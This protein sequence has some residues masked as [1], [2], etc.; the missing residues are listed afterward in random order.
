MKKPNVIVTKVVSGTVATSILISSCNIVEYNLDNSVYGSFAPNGTK[1]VALIDISDTNLSADVV[2]KIKAISQIVNEIINNPNAA[3][4]FAEN[5][6]IYLHGKELDFKINLSHEEKRLLMAFA[7]KDMMNAIKE[8][9]FESFLRIGKERGYIGV[10]GNR[11]KEDLRSLFKSEEEYNKFMESIEGSGTVL[12]GAPGAPGGSGMP[13]GGNTGG[14]NTGGDNSGDE[15]PGQPGPVVAG[16]A[17]VVA[18]AGAI[19]YVGVESIGIAQVG[20]YLHVGVVGPPGEVGVPGQRS[21]PLNN[22]EPVIKLW[23]D[24]NQPVEISDF[25]NEMIDEQIDVLTESVM[26]HYPEVDEYTLRGMLRT[27]L[28]G[29]YG[30]RK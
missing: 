6:S 15:N 14:G 30:L 21:M 17:F 4:S 27:T 9:D 23:Y 24:N 16:V 19:V 29:Y 8:E 10:I 26:K 5:P 25:Y 13:G 2:E 12:Y 18:V 11:T 1:G 28:E 3:K 20:V 22:R 7:D